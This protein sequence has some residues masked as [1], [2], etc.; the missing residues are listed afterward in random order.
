M[1]DAQPLTSEVE[2]TDEQIAEAEGPPCPQIKVYLDTPAWGTTVT[3]ATFIAIFQGDLTL[4]FLPKAADVPMAIVAFVAFIIFAVELVGNLLGGRDYGALPGRAKFNL[5][6][7]LDVIGTL[8][9]VPDFLI[10]FSGQEVGVPREAALAR[11]ARAARIGARLSRLTKVFRFEGGESKFAN[12]FEKSG[13]SVGGSKEGEGEEETEEEKE[14]D[15][16]SVS[17]QVGI[18]VADGLSK[19]IVLLVIILLVFVP[20]LTYQLP[21]TAM[22]ELMHMMKTLENDEDVFPANSTIADIS[23]STAL[24]QLEDFL[25]FQIIY[26]RWRG[27]AVP[28]YDAVD[29]DLRKVEKWE[30]EIGDGLD[31]SVDDDSGRF[32]DKTGMK[33]ILDVTKATTQEAMLN[34][35]FMLFIILIFVVSSIAFMADVTNLV[36]APV[37]TMTDVLN[38]LSGQL[39][40]LGADSKDS[41]EVNYIESCVLKIVGLL[42][43]SFGEA[44]EKIIQRNMVAGGEGDS[45]IDALVPGQKVEGCFGFCDI[46]QFTETTECLEEDIVLFVNEVGRVVHT[47]T[48]KTSGAP[49]KNVGD[50]FLSVWI[51]E[52]KENLASQA[53]ECYRRSIIMLERSKLLQE[54]ASRPSIQ[55][56]FPKTDDFDGYTVRVGFGLHWGWAIEG[57]IGSDLKVDASYLGED[58]EYSDV[59]EATTKKYNLGSGILMSEEF[60]ERLPKEDQQ[61]CRLIDCVKYEESDETARK[62]YNAEG[63]ANQ[64]PKAYEAS[65]EAIPYLRKYESGTHEYLKGNWENAMSIFEEC[66]EERPDDPVLKVITEFMEQTD[67]KPPSDWDGFRFV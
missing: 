57:A 18:A 64:R 2:L 45:N 58:V 10:I 24:A 21:D 28:Y 36:I 52:P 1:V 42:K 60:Y 41:A 25:D 31:D 49:N 46:R 54:L 4:M 12:A 14:K 20:I 55:S 3:I 39:S 38:S 59:L 63:P 9:L 17:G 8:S 11:V 6:F 19:R 22:S 7:F 66:R 43:V 62:L 61:L 29:S 32:I 37:E 13:F 15:E 5:F 33:L 50:A 65:Q 67:G 47:C 40:M 56:R 48:K 16:D 51:E 26:F 27:G 35:L 23:E 34:S 30:I 44:G 53:L